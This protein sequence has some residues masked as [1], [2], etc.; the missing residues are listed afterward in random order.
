MTLPSIWLILFICGL[1]LFS[2]SL[3]TPALPE[4]AQALKTS[5][6]AVEYTLTIY[7]GFFA[8]GV[9]YWGKL[10]DK[11]GRKPCLLLGFFVYLIGCFGCYMSSSISFL[12]LS[13][14]VQAF[15]GS[16]GSVLAQVVARDSFKGT[17]LLKVY[18][19][20]GAGLAVFP[21]LG[22]IIG[23]AITQYFHWSYVFLLLIICGIL[24]QIMI[25]LYLP[26]TL[27]ALNK[28]SH[29][30]FEVI[31]H[32]VK[33]KRV[34]IYGSLVGLAH[35][36]TFGY[37]AEGPFVLIETLGL[38][39]TQYGKSFFLTAIGSVLGG[40]IAKKWPE[41]N[42]V[43]FGSSVIFAGSLMVLVASFTLTHSVL[44]AAILFGQVFI[45]LGICMTT[46]EA[47]AVALK[48]YQWCMGTA[49]SLFGFFYYTIISLFTFG[50]GYLHNGSVVLMPLYF[51]VTSIVMLTLT[52][53]VEREA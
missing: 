9:L 47:L 42:N 16:V 32:L 38:S 52:R 6:S 7:L 24:L 51:F 34:L 25:T 43:L 20:I 14:A 30:I 15:G 1:P 21:A 4:I 39:E 2:E 22:P 27:N 17:R 48:D 40:L 3:Y 50:L 36:I 41:N 12:M 18:A 8:L 23:G 11:L 31:L 49:S 44:V 13:R 26:E 53:F 19:A 45:S 37:F 46:S 33:D 5:A 29:P 28:K 35:G 10:S